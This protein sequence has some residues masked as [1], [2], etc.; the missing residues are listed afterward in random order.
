MEDK[1]KVTIEKHDGEVKEFEGSRLIGVLGDS[2]KDTLLMHGS[3]SP[4]ILLLSLGIIGEEITKY[5]VEVGLTSGISKEETLQI[6]LDKQVELI[7]EP[8][9]NNNM[10]YYIPAEMLPT[11]KKAFV[12]RREQ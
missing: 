4:L 3:S 10:G 8:E 1:I 12:I 7:N 9:N 2:E 11:D 5:L 6:I